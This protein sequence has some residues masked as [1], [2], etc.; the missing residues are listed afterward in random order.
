MY[1][2][3][4]FEG[5][6]G[7]YLDA[8]Q[9]RLWGMWVAPPARGRG[10]GRALVEAVTDWARVRAFGRL[11]L[12]VSDAA[13][14]AERLYRGLGF[15]PTGLERRWSPTPRYGQHALRA[16]ARARAAP[17]GDGAAHDPAS[18]CPPTSGRCTRIHASEDVARWL[19][20]D[21]STLEGDPAP[22]SSGASATCA[23]ASAAT[24]SASRSSAGRTA[25]WS[26]TSRCFLTSAEHRQGELGFI[27]HPRHHG[28][29]YA[30]EAA[31][32]MLREL[33]FGT[34]ELHRVTGRAEE[35]N[36]ASATA[37]WRSS[38]CGARRTSSRTTSSRA[39]GRARS[40]TRSSEPVAAPEVG[41]HPGQ[42]H[43]HDDHDLA[44]GGLRLLA[45]HVDV[46]PPDGRDER[47]RQ[48][49]DRDHGQ[50]AE[51]LVERCAIT[52]SLVCSSA[53]TTS[54]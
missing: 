47:E 26:A 13:A 6:A 49:D 5:M 25:R 52:D 17:D 27:F 33:A 2:A 42:H 21:P 50:H 29:G 14:A 1:V 3:G 12:T 36:V 16:R 51:G 53:S 28:R 40:P 32:A 39:S 54:L 30:T 24:R 38:A 35:R 45:G 7:V 41:D 19:Y 48:E 8:E 44:E 4:D 22:G 43:D 15:A 11:R 9:P 46:H 18:S 20:E 31:G 23:S 34:F 10:L 37:C